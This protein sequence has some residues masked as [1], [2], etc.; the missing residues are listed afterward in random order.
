MCE[1]TK[2][3]YIFATLLVENFIHV[4]IVGSAIITLKLVPFKNLFL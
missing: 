3:F 4:N 1:I 2:I